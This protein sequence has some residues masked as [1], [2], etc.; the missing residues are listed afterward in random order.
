M[1]DESKAGIFEAILNSFLKPFSSDVQAMAKPTVAATIPLYNRVCKELLPTPTKPHYTFNLR[2]L[3]KVFQGTLMCSSKSVVDAVQFQRL[4]CHECKRIYQD[5][6]I[7]DTDKK[8]FDGL[9]DEML[10]EHFNSAL[11]KVVTSEYLIY[12][13]YMVPGADP[14]IYDEVKDMAKLQARRARS[15]S[16]TTTPSQSPRCTLVMFSTPSSTCRGS[17]A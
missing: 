3:A 8:W 15:T 6:M 5:R 7:N 13:D 2:D 17:A 16:P 11:D 1:S 10:K 4:W 12:G 14:K 9:L